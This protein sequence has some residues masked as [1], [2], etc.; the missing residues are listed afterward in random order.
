MSL[1]LG[2][3]AIAISELSGGAGGPSVGFPWSVKNS[4]DVVYLVNGTVLSSAG[5][6]YAVTSTVLSSAGTSYAVI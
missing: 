6:A 1:N 2:T 5:V 4:T 3:L